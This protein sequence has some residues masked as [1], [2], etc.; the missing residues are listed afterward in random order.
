[1]TSHTVFVIVRLLTNFKAAAAFD[2]ILHLSYIGMLLLPSMLLLNVLLH[3]NEAVAF[4]NQSIHYLLGL[5]DKYVDPNLVGWDPKFL[6]DLLVTNKWNTYFTPILLLIL[7]WRNP[8]SIFLISSTIPPEYHNFNVTIALG[9]YYFWLYWTVALVLTLHMNIVWNCIFPLSF[10]LKQLCHRKKKSCTVND[11]RKPQR[12]ASTYICMQILTNQMNICF[13]MAVMFSIAKKSLGSEITS[14]NTSESSVTTPQSMPVST[15]ADNF[16]YFLYNNLRDANSFEEIYYEKDGSVKTLNFIPD[17]PV[18]VLIHGFMSGHSPKASNTFPQNTKNAYIEEN[19]QT[20]A[21]NIIIMDWSS[22]SSS[23]NTP[24]SRVLDSYVIAAGNV[25]V[26]GKRLAE[27]LGYFIEKNYVSISDI[28]IVGHSLGAHVSGAAGGAIYKHFGLK[29]ER[30]SGLDPAGPGFYL[31]RS[32]SSKDAKFVDVLHT[33][34][35]TYGKATQIGHVDFY[36]ELGTLVQP[37]CR[38]TTGLALVELITLGVCSHSY[39][40]KLFSRSVNDRN[41]IAC[42]CNDIQYILDLCGPCNVNTTGAAVV[43]EHVNTTIPRGNYYFDAR[44]YAG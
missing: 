6:E 10:L 5:Q 23:A 17:I 44:N 42:K 21:R 33:S 12:A 20:M 15:D 30:I 35:G 14:E 4:I 19:N 24:V 7:T 40:H 25:N 8:G 31:R 28:H 39:S 41:M 11:F 1:L 32:L 16:R 38:N 3:R 37:T 13:Q 2:L 34:R 18:I 9:C 26:A 27:V 22:L 36:S 43:G 29:V